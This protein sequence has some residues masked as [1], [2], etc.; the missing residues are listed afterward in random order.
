MPWW[1]YLA[2]F[3]VMFLEVFCASFQNQN[4]I[5]RKWLW[6]PP[7]SY[8]MTAAKVT[9]VSVLA[10]LAVNQDFYALAIMGLVIGTAGWT[11]QY[12]AMWVH[13]GNHKRKFG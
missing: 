2:M 1:G 8:M 7:T 4:A 12:A 9:N 11:A 10:T 6:I 3:G 5:Y 13:N